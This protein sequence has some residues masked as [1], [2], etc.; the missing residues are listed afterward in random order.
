MK[1]L[2]LCPAWFTKAREVVELLDKIGPNSLHP[3]PRVLQRLSSR[4]IVNKGEDILVFLR[5]QA[6][7]AGVL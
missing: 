2:G 4:A 1:Y 7:A 5:A 6:S 3:D